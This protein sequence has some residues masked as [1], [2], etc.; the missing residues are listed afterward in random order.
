MAFSHSDLTMAD[1]RLARARERLERQRE[2]IQ[3][4]AV[5]RK[6]TARAEA[7]FK[8]MR[9]TLEGFEADRRAIEDELF[10]A[11]ANHS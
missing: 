10:A 7:L 8:V 2:I 9:R 11:K 5:G 6:D 3:E 4:L 1:Q